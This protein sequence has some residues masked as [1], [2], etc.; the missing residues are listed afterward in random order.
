MCKWKQKLSQGRGESVELLPDRTEFACLLIRI[1]LHYSQLPI[2]YNCKIAFIESDNLESCPLDDTVFHCTQLFS[3]KKWHISKAKEIIHLF[4][5]SLN[6]YPVP[7][8]FW[9][10]SIWIAYV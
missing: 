6:F 10:W 9:I 4:N 3:Y 1:I 5:K 7:I 2:I 8:S